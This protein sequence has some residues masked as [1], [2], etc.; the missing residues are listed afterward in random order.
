MA[1][2][3]GEQTHEEQ[4][5]KIMSVAQKDPRGGQWVRQLEGADTVVVA[6]AIGDLHGPTETGDAKRLREAALALVQ[7]RVIKQLRELVGEVTRLIDTTERLESSATRLQYVAIAV[8]VA[9]LV[10][11]VALFVYSR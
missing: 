8:G 3:M 7:G 10:A 4:L 11:A 1:P 2:A 9:Q 6:M 5:E